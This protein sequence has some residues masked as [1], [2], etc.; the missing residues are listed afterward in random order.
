MQ[1]VKYYRTYLHITYQHN[2]TYMLHSTELNT[3]RKT[4]NTK[5][6]FYCCYVPINDINDPILD[7]QKK[8]FSA[9]NNFMLITM[10][11]IHRYCFTSTYGHC[12]HVTN[13]MNFNDQLDF[14]SSVTYLFPTSS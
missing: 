12:I 1:H 7:E 14:H 13:L 2:V 5:T 8:Q 9:C 10:N 11:V 4:K 6:A 3:E